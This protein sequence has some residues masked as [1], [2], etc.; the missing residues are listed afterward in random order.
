MRKPPAKLNSPG[1]GPHPHSFQTI[2]SGW[3]K[4]SKPW[5]VF[6]TPLHSFPFLILTA[7]PF[8][9]DFLC[10]LIFFLVWYPMVYTSNTLPLSHVHIQNETRYLMNVSPR[11]HLLEKIRTMGEKNERRNEVKVNG[12]PVPQP[13]KRTLLV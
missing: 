7:F 5:A 11:S 4:A 2:Y 8:V 1:S 10:R 12:Q 9:C 3:F 13:I 6:P